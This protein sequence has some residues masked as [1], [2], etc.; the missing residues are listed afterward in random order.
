MGQLWV[1]ADARKGGAGEAETEKPR[2][3]SQRTGGAEVSEMD[4]EQRS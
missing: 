4:V 2:R 3:S 1:T